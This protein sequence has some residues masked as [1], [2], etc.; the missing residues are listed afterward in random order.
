MSAKKTRLEAARALLATKPDMSPTKA[1]EALQKRGYE[2]ATPGYISSLK[3]QIKQEGKTGTAKPKKGNAPMVT[4]T[5]KIRDRFRKNPE[6]HPK[7]VAEE[8][9]SSTTHCYKLRRD[10]REESDDEPRA[11]SPGTRRSKKSP[12][13]VSLSAIKSAKS[14]IDAFGG[15]DKAIEAVDAISDMGGASKAKATLEAI[16]IFT[17]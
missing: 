12:D 11:G 4:K 7:S 6:A 3:T 14:L 16:A 17:A 15:V 8:F 2:D 1:S 9:G 13:K 10:V 5:D